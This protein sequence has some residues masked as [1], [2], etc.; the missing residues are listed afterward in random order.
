MEDTRKGAGVDLV[1]LRRCQAGDEEAFAQLF[2]EYKNL[3]YRA[4]Y[5]TLGNTVDAEDILQDVFL[6]VHRSLETYDSNRGAFTTWLHRITVNRCLNWRRRRPSVD[7]L[8]EAAETQAKARAGGRDVMPDRYADDDCVRR[9][10]DR[11]SVKL[12]AVVVLRHYCDLSYA[13]IAEILDLPLG[14]VKSRLHLA[15]R[16]LHEELKADYPYHARSVTEVQR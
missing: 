16:T 12:R 5:L 9:A 3:V 2:E 1:L 6:Q 15:L 4:A 11:L 14:T 13:E 10:L 8:D 7:S